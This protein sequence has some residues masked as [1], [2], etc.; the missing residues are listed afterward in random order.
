MSGH[1]VKESV[2][3]SVRNIVREAQNA[4]RESEDGRTITKHLC[5]I[6]SILKGKLNL[7]C[8]APTTVVYIFTMLT[9]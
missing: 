6:R 8:K 7:K 3:S 9:T 5:D 2:K 1:K 4:I